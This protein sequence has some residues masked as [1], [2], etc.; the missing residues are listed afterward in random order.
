[1]YEALAGD[2]AIKNLWVI[3]ADITLAVEARAAERH[4]HRLL[5][6]EDALKRVKS[7]FDFV[8][9]DCRPAIDLPVENALL[10]ANLVIMPVDMD[11]RAV[12]GLDDLHKV[13]IELKR[14]ESF[15]SLVVRVK[16]D[17]RNTVMLERVGASLMEKP[18]AIANASIGINESFKHASHEHRPFFF[19]KRNT[20]QHDEYRAFT[21]EVL[22]ILQDKGLRFKEMETQGVENAT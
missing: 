9:M 12:K 5:I 10:I 18:W 3:P 21:D 4:R 20:P 22:D 15:K 19:Y 16:V 14:T 7:R 17:R 2:M 1:M 8:V 6:L 13:M 11:T